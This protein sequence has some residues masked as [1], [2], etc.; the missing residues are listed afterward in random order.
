MAGLGRIMLVEDEPEECESFHIAL[1][2]QPMMKIVFETGS[3]SRALDYLEAH[4]VDIII[5]DIELKEGDGLSLLDSI[6]TRKLEKPFIVVVTNTGSNVTL[7][8]M[9]ENGADYVYQKTNL[10]YSAARV[11][12]IV[13]KVYPYR[14]FINRRRSSHLVEQFNQEKADA[15]T[16]HYVES[17]LE[18]IGFRRRQVGFSYIAEAILI[19]MKDKDERLRLTSDIYPMIAEANNTTSEGVERGIR[20]AIETAFTGARIKELHK[21]YPFP[22]KE[23]KGR[24]SNMEFLKNMAMRLRL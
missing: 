16:R 7:N 20:G 13:E 3:E 2:R 6:R 19:I 1:L 12:S 8:Y 5:L 10:S 22:Y 24:P 21:A 23:S 11:L 4:E 17:E 9:R 14:D 15:I 18:R